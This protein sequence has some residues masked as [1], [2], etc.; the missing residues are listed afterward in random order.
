VGRLIQIVG[1]SANLCSGGLGNAGNGATNHPLPLL[2]S[3][4]YH[5][6]IDNPFNTPLAV[7]R[8][9][10]EG[11]Q[12]WVYADKPLMRS[13]QGGRTTFAGGGRQWF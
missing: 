3:Q 9:G 4:T 13:T 8:A 1:Q 10:G 7:A 6:D 5:H 11:G 12:I 2:F